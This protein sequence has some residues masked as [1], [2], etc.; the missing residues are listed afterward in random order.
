MQLRQQPRLAPCVR[1][2]RAPSCASASP[3]ACRQAQ[4]APSARTRAA[5]TPQVGALRALPV[6]ILSAAITTTKDGKVHD[7]FEVRL[8]GEGVTA[9]DVQ[10]AVHSALYAHMHHKRARG[11]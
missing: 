9:E 11:E 8:E 1:H 2:L 3:P 6:L 10:C 7:V 5:P 4:A